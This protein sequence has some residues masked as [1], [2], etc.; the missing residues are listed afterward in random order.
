MA[1][2]MEALTTKNKELEKALQDKAAADAS[3]TSAHADAL[4]QLRSK[5]EAAAAELHAELASLRQAGQKEAAELRQ[6]L[7][8]EQAAA[9]QA[10]TEQQ[11]ELDKLH[12]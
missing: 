11:E 1:A 9:E 12:E 3:T 2:Q 6:Q 4:Q 7:E 10:K 8:Q 5:M